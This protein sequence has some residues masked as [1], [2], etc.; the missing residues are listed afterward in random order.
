M[1]HIEILKAELAHDIPNNKIH[2][3]D[4]Y[5]I[6]WV[7]SSSKNLQNII[8][9]VN[10]KLKISNWYTP[11]DTFII[12]LDENTSDVYGATIDKE[13][14]VKICFDRDY[15]TETPQFLSEILKK[16]QI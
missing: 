6:Y 13:K 8:E 2:G 1:T 14:N 16:I 10:H 5:I 4:G 7:S 15:K 11:Y 9:N 3:A 12:V